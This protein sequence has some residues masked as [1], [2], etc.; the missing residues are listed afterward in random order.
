MCVE[1]NRNPIVSTSGAMPCVIAIKQKHF[2]SNGEAGSIYQLAE[3]TCLKGKGAILQSEAFSDSAIEN[4]AKEDH[5]Y[6]IT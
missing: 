5:R 1:L 6:N 3:I 2:I 4:L